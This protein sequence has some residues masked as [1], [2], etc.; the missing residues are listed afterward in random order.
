M[1]QSLT[2]FL[3]RVLGFSSSFHH[4]I[5]QPIYIMLRI[6][7]PKSLRAK[8]EL[9]KR[10]PK[11]V[12][13]GK[14][15]LILHGTKTSNTLNAVLTEIYHLKKDNAVK[16]SR[17]NDNIRPFESGGETSLEFYSLKTDC[18]L[19][20]YGSHSKKRPDNLVIGRTYD[21]HIYDLV[22]IGVENFKSM[23]SCSYDKK[24]APLIG[25]KPF[26]AFIGEGF[27]NVEELK[28]LKEVLL[29]LFRGQVVSNLNLAGL[30]R[31]YVCT[32]VSSNKVLFTHCALRLKKSGTVVPRVEL[33]E[34]GPSM[35]LVVRRHRLP[36]EGL[37]KEAHKVPH[38]LIKKKEKNVSKDAIAG[39]IGKIYV[40]DQQVGSA[41]LPF[42]PK[43]VKR[44][45]R[46]A[47]AKGEDKKHAEKKQ[48]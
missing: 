46:E 44:E 34:V 4:S 27:E 38:E 35:D 30:D 16:Y 11:L 48:K 7:T 21:H 6:K 47:K 39:K 42:T 45:R 15:T 5:S 26:F 37:K 14:K 43:G 2:P 20:V 22:E 17:R 1:N 19:F 3:S 31:V 36:D 18:S 40:P 9:E 24:L 32:A 25:S 12:E 8:R 13:R 29:D 10:A 28:H 33:V 41:S 23:S